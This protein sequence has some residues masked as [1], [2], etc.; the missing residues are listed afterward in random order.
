MTGI[1]PEII[2][3]KLQ[4]DPYYQPRKKKIRK[5][6]PER[7][8]A[9]NEEIQKLIEN[10]FVREVHYPEW[11]ANVVIVKKKNGKLRAER[12]LYCL[13]EGQPTGTWKLHVD[14]SSNTKESGLGLVL[15]SPQGDIIEKVVRCR[16]K[17]TNNE[18]EYKAMI[19]GLVLAKE[20]GIRQLNVFSDSQLIVNQMQGSY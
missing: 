14:G 8:K 10:R 13:T 17:A 15:T 19:V 7:N 1:V 12:A 3:H 5:F 6:T 18:A 11:L 20:M 4:V 16:F 2:V 9:F